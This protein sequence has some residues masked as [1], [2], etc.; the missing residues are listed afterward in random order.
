MKIIQTPGL[1]I[2]SWCND[3]EDGTI[4]QAF[5]LAQLPFAHHHIALMPDTHQGYG[6][7]IGGVL[8]AEGVIIPNAV[9]VDIGCGM[10]ACRTSLNEISRDMIKKIMGEIRGNIPVGFKHRDE[11]QDIDYPPGNASISIEEYESARRQAGTLGG[12]NHFIEI[13]AGS[14]GF[15]WFMIHSGSRNIGKKVCDHYNKTAK[16]LKSRKF[17]IPEKWDLA[18][19]PADSEIGC[20]YIAE[21]EY[22]QKFA[23]ENRNKMSDII[24]QIFSEVFSPLKLT[25]DPVYNVHHNYARLE[26]HFGKKVWVHRKGAISARLRETGIIPGSQGT[27]SYIV[28]GLGNAD[29]FE[30]CSHGA[31][32]RMGRKEAQRTLVLGDEIKY[33]EKKG[34]IHGMRSVKDLDEAAG[35]YKNIDVVMKEQSDLTEI[36]LELIPLGVIKG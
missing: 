2:Y 21:M 3:P 32:R 28:K 6:M 24:I 1:K 14:D 27:K 33:M 13:Q 25:F 5:N 35:A 4:E 30:S 16:Q 9:G 17:S 10:L 36:T 22:C 11:P 18:Y 12:G 23:A 20:Q 7:P 26:H 8:A 19:L 29:S 15:I 34:I 31:G